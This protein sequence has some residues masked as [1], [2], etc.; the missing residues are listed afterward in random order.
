MYVRSLALW[1]QRFTEEQ[2]QGKACSYPLVG[3]LHSYGVRLRL[4]KVGPG[5]KQKGKLLALQRRLGL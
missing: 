5:K 2:V 3:E 1:H 4:G